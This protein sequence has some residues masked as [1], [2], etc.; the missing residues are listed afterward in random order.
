MKIN[1]Q[2]SIRKS[3]IQFGIY[4]QICSS[5]S[6]TTFLKPRIMQEKNQKCCFFGT[7]C[8]I[9][10]NI[11]NLT[12]YVRNMSSICSQICQVPVPRKYLIL[13]RYSYIYSIFLF[14]EEEKISNKRT[15]SGLWATHV[16][17]LTYSTYQALSS[18]ASTYQVLTTL[19]F[20]N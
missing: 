3:K 19:Y 6:K 4:A 16:R 13:R 12:K 11:L 8:K 2:N 20:L 7:F 9:K 15:Q 10:S 5:L 14:L 18:S 1:L 17:D